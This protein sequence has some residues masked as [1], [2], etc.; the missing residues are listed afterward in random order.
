MNKYS[1][2][3]YF[4]LVLLGHLLGAAEA[5]EGGGFPSVSVFWSGVRALRVF[6]PRCDSGDDEM[7]SRRKQEAVD[8]STTGGS[9]MENSDTRCHR[10]VAQGPCSFLRRGIVL[11]LAPLD[12]FHRLRKRTENIHHGSDLQLLPCF[13][14]ERGVL[15]QQQNTDRPINMSA[16]YSRLL[17]RCVPAVHLEILSNTVCRRKFETSSFFYLL[18]LRLGQMLNITLSGAG[19]WRLFITTFHPPPSVIS[20]SYCRACAWL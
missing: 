8:N 2:R 9:E 14:P 17:Q 20:F 4:E 5:A 10:Q 13:P 1:F 3:P 16:S 19:I 18:N 6:S 12:S 15:Q 11:L 7:E